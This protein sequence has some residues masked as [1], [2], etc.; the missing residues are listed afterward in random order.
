MLGEQAGRGHPWH[1]AL[2]H[3]DRFLA[4]VARL[5]GWTWRM[6]GGSGMGSSQAAVV[7]L[8]QEAGGLLGLVC[9]LARSR[10]DVGVNTTQGLAAGVGAW[11]QGGAPEGLQAPTA[12]NSSQSSRTSEQPAAPHS[13]AASSGSSA[14]SSGS[15]YN[16][17]MSATDTATLYFLVTVAE[18]DAG[19]CLLASGV[20][21]AAGCRCVYCAPITF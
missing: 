16:A 1:L 19:Q 10:D 14:G 15:S 17:R 13:S 21:C 5:S 18:G 4:S 9:E 8:A 12:G 3:V 20:M 6:L 2:A 11:Q 7:E